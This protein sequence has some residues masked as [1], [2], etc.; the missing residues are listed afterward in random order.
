MN[1]LHALEVGTLGT[2]PVLLRGHTLIPKGA[3]HTSVH[4]VTRQH[5]HILITANL[6]TRT[7]QIS[8][9]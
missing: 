4:T 3:Q 6:I 5:M 8:L 7:A 9:C 1:L 2:E